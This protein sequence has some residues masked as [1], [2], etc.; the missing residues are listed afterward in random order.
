MD[1]HARSRQWRPGGVYP[2]TPE[3]ARRSPRVRHMCT[4]VN[5]RFPMRAYG[6][7]VL[8]LTASISIVFTMACSTRP[9]PPPEGTRVS[10]PFGA[11]D[12]NELSFEIDSSFEDSLEQSFRDEPQQQFDPDRD[13]NS[14]YALLALS[15]GGSRGAFGAGVLA[16]WTTAG[17]RPEFKVVSGVSTGAL[18]ATFAF[19][20][21]DYDQT[22]RELY[23]AF[24]NRD[25]YRKRWRV[26]AVFS[27]AT[28]DTWPLRELIEHY[29]T[30][31]VI[32][33]VAR[34]HTKGYR[35]FVGT[36][37]M[38]T[39]EFIIWDLGKVASS[40]RPGALAQYRRI[41]MASSAVPVLFPPVYF[42][43][44][45]S[46]GNTYSEMH[47]D[48]ATYAQ[49]FFR[50][51]MLDFEDAMLE[52]D[53]NPNAVEM[54]LYIIRNGLADE[55]QGRDAVPPRTISIAKKTIESLFK[56]SATSAMYRIYVLAKRNGIRFNLA[57]IPQQYE[58]DLNVAEFDAE[59]MKMLFEY[60][61]HA[62]KDGYPWLAQPPF[63]DPDE[64]FSE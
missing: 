58:L 13:G 19:L 2:W 63:L 12:V 53:I 51:F 4:R 9:P 38:D 43:V 40:G 64:V 46:D 36:T 24:G 14:E 3:A 50:G 10:Q 7:L 62:A 22:L 34:K 55:A 15:G 61:Y 59:A 29:I 21:P 1:L 49:L 45:A 57:A 27:D 30:Q 16:G 35:L 54:D 6:K 25:F 32:D 20:G 23:T 42:E 56:I 52:A 37:N 17:T 47:V 41:L 60:G 33:A 5:S 28:H 11:I 44:E 39:M 31:D 18:Q 26:A 48:G 8:L